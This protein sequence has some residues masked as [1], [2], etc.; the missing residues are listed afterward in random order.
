M[1]DCESCAH[2][3]VC[4]YKYSRNKLEDAVRD[5]A[6][7]D[8]FSWPLTLVLACQQYEPAEPHGV[9]AP[10]FVGAPYWFRQGPS[11]G[12][13]YEQAEPGDCKVTLKGGGEDGK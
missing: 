8:G 13:A 9:A 5:L 2:A 6:D 10:W 3:K 11:C 12:T 4:Q 7:Q 1:Q